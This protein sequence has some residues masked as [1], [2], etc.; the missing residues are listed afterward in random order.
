MP[1]LRERPLD[2]VLQADDRFVK[3]VD[4]VSE[5]RVA[6]GSLSQRPGPAV[7]SVRRRAIARIWSVFRLALVGAVVWLAA[8][9]RHEIADAARQ[10]RALSP[11]VVLVIPLFMAWNLAGVA[12]WRRLIEAADEGGP[13]P[14]A[15]ALWLIRLQAQA[16][17]LLVPSGGVGG[18][19]LRATLLSKR[20]GRA[21]HGTSAVV[22]D[23]LAS[24]S[25]GVLFSVA[26]LATG[27]RLYPATGP[28]LAAVII[29]GGALVALCAS[30][31]LALTVAALTRGRPAGKTLGP[32]LAL[33]RDSPKRL[34]VGYAQIDCVACRRAHA[35]GR[36]DLCC[37][38]RPRPGRDAVGRPVCHRHDDRADARVLLRSRPG[39]PGGARPG[40]RVLRDRLLA[41]GRPDGGPRATGPPGAGAARRQRDAPLHRTPAEDRRRHSGSVTFRPRNRDM[42]TMCVLPSEHFGD[43]EQQG[44]LQIR[45]LTRNG[46][47]VLPVVGPGPFWSS[48]ISCPWASTPDVVNAAARPARRRQR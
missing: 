12:G 40:R 6:A 17:N 45:W 18:E 43:A 47:D 32:V 7:T 25:A 19:V 29:A 48:A 44:I 36:R 27:R 1:P 39:R 28:S 38:A 8:A 22:L 37:D 9:H 13:I 4:A 46:F 2:S 31:P 16:V 24:T 21:V 33:F 20:T 11:V 5:V 15:W 42:K 41:H 35:H 34:A 14:S 30:L 10:L 3:A 26:W 23:N